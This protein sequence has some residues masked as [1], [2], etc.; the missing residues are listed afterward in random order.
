MTQIPYLRML[1]WVTAVVFTAIALIVAVAFPLHASDALAFGE[2]SRLIALHWS[3]VFDASNRPL[4]YVLQGSLWH[5]IG[6]S[7]SSG[8][9]LCGLFS[10]LLVAALAWLVSARPWGRIAAAV[11]VLLVLATPVYAAQVVSSLTD[12]VVAAMLALTAA[13]AVRLPP[14]GRTLPLA[15]MAAMLAVLAKPSALLALIGIAASQLLAKE[16]LRERM[17]RR[18]VPLAAGTAIGFSYYVIQAARTHNGLRPFLEAGVTGPY[19][20]HLAAA[21]RRLGI[22]DLAWFG[23]LLRSVLLFALLYTVG[24]LAGAAHRATVLA[25]VPAVAVLSWF[26][27]W[28]G[29]R[30]SH[31][32][33]GAFANASSVAA[34][35]IT[36]CVLLAAAWA[37][38][39][40]VPT[41]RELL[42]FVLWAV[43]PLVAWMAYATYDT[44]LL[45]SAWP[46]LLALMAVC[47]TPAVVGLA[48]IPAAALAPI[49]AL[50]V[51]VSLNIYNIDGLG[52]S[53]WDQWRRTPSS[54]RFNVDQ[55]RAIVLPALT[56]ALAVVRP[57]MGPRDRLFSPEG[58]FRFFFPGRVEQSFPTSCA[59]LA[60]YRAF[61]LTTDQGSRSYMQD[62]LHVSGDPSYWAACKQPHLRQLTNGAEGYAVFAVNG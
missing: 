55:T 48:R 11:A 3:R 37:P 2:W 36:C 10:L 29:G 57:L 61:V 1:T 45:S 27:P 12:V 35:M 16:P 20:S 32:S 56:K 51:A 49:V 54:E 43:P 14:R 28:I 47:G 25:A 26:L 44:R 42:L 21:T 58:A 5:V 22:L 23:E 33:V 8:R 15:G 31:L 18:V 4:F 38:D 41:R 17:L 59:E 13:L 62:F 9:L 24:R 40:A 19:Y 50:I 52:R 34:W 6:Y 7:D 60:G 46:G 53:G 30:E 39:E